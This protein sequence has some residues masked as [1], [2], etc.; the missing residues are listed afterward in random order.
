MADR[1]RYVSEIGL[2]AFSRGRQT[3]RWQ[4]P[5]CQRH[6]YAKK[7][8]AVNPRLPEIDE[9]DNFYWECNLGSAIARDIATAIGNAR[10]FRF[11]VRGEIWYNV[12]DI[13]K[14]CSILKTLYDVTFWIPT[15]AWHDPIMR[16]EIEFEVFGKTNARVLA[17]IDPSDD[18]HEVKVL[19]GMGWSTV[20][21]GDNEDPDQM[22]LA[23]NGIVPKLS[24]DMHR[25][26][27]TWH[28]RTGHCAVCE[29]GCFA[30]HRVDVHLKEHR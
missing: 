17:S 14:V 22:L 12:R 11:A 27:K 16:R 1:I 5:W 8:Y 9:Q 23:S 26:E 10:R 24:A 15:R 2:W 19:R 18:E 29:D 21:A 4:T 7:F 28:H 6:C 20:F 3:C 13:E 25:C 30:S